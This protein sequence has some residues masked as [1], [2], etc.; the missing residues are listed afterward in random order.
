MPFM[1]KTPNIREIFHE[2]VVIRKKYENEHSK[3]AEKCY[4]FH[5]KQI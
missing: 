4:F 3:R 2:I 1:K 5:K